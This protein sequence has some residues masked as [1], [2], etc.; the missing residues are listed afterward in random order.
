VHGPV[1]PDRELGLLLI[2]EYVRFPDE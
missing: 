2:D 1:R